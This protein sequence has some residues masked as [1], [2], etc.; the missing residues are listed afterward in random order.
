M[1]YRAVSFRSF[2]S[3]LN[4]R[5]Q[6]DVVS[7][8]EAIDLLNVTFTERGG[9]KQRDG[10]A[11]FTAAAGTNRYDSLS[12]F[13]TVGGT[14][15]LVAGAGNRLEALSAAGAIVASNTTPT[16]NPHYFA[17]FGA[18]GSEHLY[19]ANGTDTVRRWDGSSFTTPTYTGTT[20]TGRF[21]AIT[22]WDNRLVVARESS[23][24]SRVRF[25]DP[26]VPTT[27]GTNNYIDLHPGDGE[28]I[29]GIVA[30]RESLFVFKETKFF[31]FYGTSTAPTG[32]PIFNYRP[33]LGGVGL[34]A[35]RALSAGRE[36]VY[37][38]S[39][40][41]VYRTTGGEPEL[42]SDVIDPFFYGG[43]SAFFLS[44]ELDHGQ[45]TK[46]AMAWH[47]ERIYLAVPTGGSAT[48]DRLLVH[49]PRYGWWSLY[50]I[51][52]A[53]LTSFR[54]AD[55]EELV[56]AYAS[57]LNHIGRHSPSYKND[58]GAAIESRWR[59][60]WFD[61]DNP[62]VKTIRETKV[63]GTGSVRI[64]VSRDFGY[65]TTTTALDFEANV[66]TWDDGTG[67]DTWGDGTGTDTWGPDYAINPKLARTA[68]RGTTLSTHFQ[69]N[70][71][72]KSWAIYRLTHHL[73]ETRHPSLTKTTT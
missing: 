47:D 46:A 20:P 72:D 45:I 5:D 67:S 6:P 59:S 37:F 73:R 24:T 34:V 8:A 15:Q 11:A 12:V 44:D 4:L 2:G 35:S 60:G 71:L 30:W 13:Y 31:V 18:P 40:Q 49:D 22:P 23:Q 66:D 63:W 57:G 61:Y 55:A 68:V 65:A 39:R 3:G 38:M 42:V 52:A 58:A 56:F 1:S 51:P 33:V 54:V 26:G 50:D 19:I 53:A 16:A 64:G 36:G 48:N 43:T 10:Y 28:A 32:K 70:T 41:G 62:N 25:S 29:T 27:F 7:E 9:V 17:R 21:V 14:K 69:N